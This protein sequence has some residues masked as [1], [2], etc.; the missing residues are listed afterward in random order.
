M[1]AIIADREL[2]QELIAQRQA[3]GADRHDEV[4]DGVYFMAPIANNEHQTLGTLLASVLTD[5]TG[6]GK[7]GKVQ[8]GANVSDR[9][10][11]WVQ[12]YR[13]PDVLVFLKGN[14]AEN[15]GNHWYGGPDLAVEIVSES[16]R[17]YEKLPFYAEVK[18]REVLIIERDPWELILF[19]LQDG[20]MMEVGRTG[21]DGVSLE[22]VVLPIKL[23]L[24]AVA[25]SSPFLVVRHGEREWKL[26]GQ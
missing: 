15:R 11:N 7:L 2:E 1:V 17:S 18:T 5:I 24:E 22:S 9:P 21:I 10:T 16:D 12:N 25:G 26:T 3:T 4:W 13:C 6:Y 20:G 8:G 14:P 23:S 19:R